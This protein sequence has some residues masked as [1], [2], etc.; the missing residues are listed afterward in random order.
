MC[1]IDK[2]QAV[3]VDHMNRLERSDGPLAKKAHIDNPVCFLLMTPSFMP[4]GR[5]QAYRIQWVLWPWTHKE[6]YVLGYLVEDYH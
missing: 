1:C 4:L 3:Y 2:A 6:F 5:S